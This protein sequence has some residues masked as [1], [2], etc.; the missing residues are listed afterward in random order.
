[1][2]GNTGHYQSSCLQPAHCTAC[3]VDGHA[4]S[5]CPQQNKLA[6]LKWYGFAIEGA[7]FFAMDFPVSEV[8]TMSANLATIFTTDSSTTP[9]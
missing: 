8:V 4:T 1:M 2:C 6:D 7:S 5:M 3:G 9:S